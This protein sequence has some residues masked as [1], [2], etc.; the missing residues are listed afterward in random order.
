MLKDLCG[1]IL[2]V[3]ILILF[4]FLIYKYFKSIGKNMPIFFSKKEGMQN[5]T[6]TEDCLQNAIN[7][8]QYFIQRPRPFADDSSFFSF[9]TRFDPFFKP[10]KYEI[11]PHKASQYAV[12]FNCRPTTTGMFTDCG[13]LAPNS[14]S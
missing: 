1:I 14:C 13:P 10:P 12:K 4:Y 6:K 3:L 5:M 7:Q 2:S 9:L 8:T 11:F